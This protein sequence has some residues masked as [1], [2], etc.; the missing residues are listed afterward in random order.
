MTDG[1]TGPDRRQSASPQPLA[2]FPWWVLPGLALTVLVI[3]AGALAASVLLD[4]NTL[5]TQMFTGAYGL[6]TL[7]VGYFFGSSAGST[8]KDEAIVATAIKA[9]ETIA[10]Q[11]KAL[12]GSAPVAVAATVDPGQ[13]VTATT[14]APAESVQPPPS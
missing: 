8:K 2:G 12:A 1:Y 4:D 14:T 13:P 9:N 6:A 11:G 10:D 7:S 3:F 5:R